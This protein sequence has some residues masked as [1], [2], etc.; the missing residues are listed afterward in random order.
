[1]KIVLGWI[2]LSIV[3]F[4]ND[5]NLT[6]EEIKEHKVIIEDMITIDKEM[7]KIIISI[8]EKI[9]SIE[10][11]FKEIDRIFENRECAE[12]EVAITERLVFEIDNFENIKKEKGYT[13][14]LD[15]LK[16]LE[17]KLKARYKVKCKKAM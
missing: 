17:N 7:D 16:G 1:M 12:L 2:L 14:S 3:G 4:G 6:S 10:N 9:I 15:T 5:L 11:T 13:F 8:D